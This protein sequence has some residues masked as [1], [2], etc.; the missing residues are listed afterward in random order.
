M[1][2]FTYSLPS[3]DDCL[4]QGDILEKNDEISSLLKEIHPHY[5]SKS[6]YTHFLVITQ[7]CDLVKRK[8]KCNT[9]YITIAA[10]RPVEIVLGR[11]VETFQNNELKKKTNICTYKDFNKLR[12]FLARLFNNND[13][14][15]F[16]LEG[17]P[18]YNLTDNL[19]AFLKLS[20]S[21]KTKHYDKCLNARRLTLS[22]EFKAKLGWLVG[23]IYSRAGTPDWVPTKLGNKAF[24]KK[25]NSLLYGQ[26]YFIDEYRLKEINKKIDTEYI[27]EKSSEE[28]TE[29][30][31]RMDIPTKKEQVI[32]RTVNLL[33][34][35]DVINKEQKTY[36]NKL[37]TNDETLSFLLK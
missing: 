36:Y 37:L 4:E 7:T 15:Y 3:S 5:Y 13:P 32:E 27:A 24:N 1:M 26:C 21:V 18:E 35:N 8:G 6:D 19:C 23:N 30:V 17:E 29:I 9:R 16:Y 31:F 25:I 12:D 22:N 10:I 2:H 34:E 14:R 28:L 33:A 20:I 11:E